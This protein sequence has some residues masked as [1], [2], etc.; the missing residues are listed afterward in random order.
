MSNQTPEDRLKKVFVDPKYQAKLVDHLV[1]NKPIGWS[2]KSN[3]PYYKE[4]YALQ[5][6]TTLDQMILD[7]QDVVYSYEDYLKHYGIAR[8]TLYLR[9][10]QSIRFLLDNL[11]PDKRYA[12]LLDRVQIN[13]ER[14]VGVT[15]KF[16]PE[17]RS[18]QSDFK[19]R[20]VEPVEQKA[21]WQKDMETWLEESDPGDEPFYKDKLALSPEEITSLKIQLKSL[22]NVLSSVTVHTIKLVKVNVEV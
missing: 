17:F 8:E 7:S 19:P 16:I 4:E 12:R 10:N 3:A 1:H 11:D 6:R 15:I 13:R 5:L 18:G 9:I 21:K 14:G 22:S 20:V 2:R